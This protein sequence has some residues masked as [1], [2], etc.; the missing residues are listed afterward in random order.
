MCTL[1]VV[2]TYLIDHNLA[3]R[4]GSL[5]SSNP[6][7]IMLISDASPVA[8]SAGECAGRSSHKHDYWRDLSFPALYVRIWSL[9]CLSLKSLL[10]P[11]AT[12]SIKR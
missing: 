5:K 7:A 8:S 6:D 4:A 11:C 10:H 2:E 1:H 12:K 3:V 9:E